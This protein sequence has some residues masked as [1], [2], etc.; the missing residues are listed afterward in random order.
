[1]QARCNRCKYIWRVR[2]LHTSC[3][4]CPVCRSYDVDYLEWGTRVLPKRHIPHESGNAFIYKRINPLFE[5]WRCALQNRDYNQASSLVDE[6]NAM[7]EQAERLN[8]DRTSLSI[9]R[10]T[11]LILTAQTIRL[12]EERARESKEETRRIKERGR[13]VIS[14]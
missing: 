8:A 3:R 6:V 13:S 7:R 9:A 5:K 11:W 12:S 2:V 4:R 1:M 14:N 10:S